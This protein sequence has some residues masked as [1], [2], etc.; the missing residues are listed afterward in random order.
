MGELLA[1]LAAAA[2]LTCKPLRHAARFSGEPPS[3]SGQANDC[4]VRLE[5]RNSAG[6]RI[7]TADLELEIYRSGDQLNLMLSRLG[8][9]EA[10]LLWHGR[11][12]V[13]MD[14]TTGERRERPADGASLEAFA[15]RVRAL[16]AIRDPA[17][18]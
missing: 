7:E 14:G 18:P 12:P 6:E 4:C 3:T 16:L 17:D 15:R 10:P 9:E 2:D 5:A 1:Q 8:D 13:W 11:H